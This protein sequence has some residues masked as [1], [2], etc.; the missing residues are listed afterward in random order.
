[1]TTFQSA[2][3]ALPARN[4]VASAQFYREKLGFTAQFY[5]PDFAV[6]TRDVVLLH[7]FKCEEEKVFEHCGCYLYVQGIR[8]LYDQL[9]PT[10][11]IHLNGYLSEKPWGLLEMAVTDPDGNQLRFMEPAKDR[12]QNSADPGYAD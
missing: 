2:A 6:L 10:G 9:L 1:M 8:E 7:L 3:P 5:G 11:C 12:A 4:V